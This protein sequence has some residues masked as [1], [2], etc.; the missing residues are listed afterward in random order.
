[1]S[2]SPRVAAKKAKKAKEAEEAEGAKRLMR[3][4]RIQIK[5]NLTGLGPVSTENSQGSRRGR[6]E[7]VEAD[8]EVA[9]Y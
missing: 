9:W 5:R 2:P 7:P 1:M 3:R 6:D 4:R 8:E